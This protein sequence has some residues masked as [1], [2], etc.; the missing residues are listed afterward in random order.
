MS[1]SEIKC[2]V[3]GLPRRAVKRSERKM[4]KQIMKDREYRRTLKEADVHGRQNAKTVTKAAV[5]AM[6]RGRE[7]V[8]QRSTPLWK[9][10]WLAIL[11]GDSRKAAK[12][13][14]KREKIRTKKLVAT[15]KRR[16]AKYDKKT[17]LVRLL[18]AKR[19]PG[20]KR[21]KPYK[22]KKK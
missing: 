2:T 22:P 17:G 7:S 11:A 9:E 15:W 19:L 21:I 4:T 6:M 20:L 1:K 8:D 5:G 14:K 18:K 10:E 12:I 13:A 16:G 3:G